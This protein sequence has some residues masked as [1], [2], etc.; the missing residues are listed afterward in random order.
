MTF[1]ASD[2]LLKWHIKNTVNKISE[3]I[4]KNAGGQD[5]SWRKKGQKFT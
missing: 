2:I 1:V 4:I 5:K 3:K